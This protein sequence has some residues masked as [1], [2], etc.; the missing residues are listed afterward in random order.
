VSLKKNVFANYLGEGWAALMGL[1]FIP[2]YIKYLGIEAYGLVGVFVLL[3]AWLALLDLGMTPTLNRE[4]ARFTAGGHTPKSI[5]N[6]LRSLEIVCAGIAGI[7]AVGVWAASGYLATDWLKVD[8]VPAH[9]AAQALGIM[10]LVLALRFCEGIYRG[11]L[12]GLQRQVLYNGL[13]AVLAT[14]RHGGAAAVLGWVSPTLEA[15]FLW[16]GVVSVLSVTVLRI[17]VQHS[18]PTVQAPPR[19]AADSLVGIWKFA[20]GMMGIAFLALML[21]QIDKV[22][23][24]RLLPLESFAYYALAATISAVLYFIV[25]PV[26]QAIYPRMV[27]LSTPD[28]EANL[29][30]VYHGSA[31]LVTVLTAPAAFLIGFFAEGVVFAW[32]GDADLARNTAPILFPLVLG[33]YLNG[34]MWMP[35]HCQLARGWTGL[36]LGVNFVAVLI[37]VPSIFLLVPQY[38]A[39]GAAWIWVGLNAGYVLIGIQL[40]HLRLIVREK[41]RWYFGDVILPAGAALGIILLGKAAQPEDYHSRLHWMLFLVIAGSCALAASALSA[42]RIRSWLI[43]SL[44]RSLRWRYS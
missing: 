22:L 5:R 35:Y 29:I 7:I 6:L 24:S 10:A 3:Q 41:W 17:S 15:F 12:L 25:R 28:D 39:V 42:D 19:F 14:L 36:T 33:T 21:T 2:V 9:V 37:L 31:Q 30:A 16:Q 4:M 32:S 1:A 23:L 44:G 27:Q 8:R 13:N 18:L 40:M 20:R 11:S 34:L 38:G 43:V 26:S